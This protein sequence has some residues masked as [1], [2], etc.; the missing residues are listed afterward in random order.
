[1]IHHRSPPRRW[2]RRRRRRRTIT[3]HP[4]PEPLIQTILKLLPPKDAIRA[5]LTSK[6]WRSAWIASPLFE[7]DEQTLPFKQAD[8]YDYVDRT[9]ALW[10]NHCDDHTLKM[11]K[12]SLCSDLGKDGIFFP[13]LIE[14]VSIA[15]NRNVKIIQLQNRSKVYSGMISSNDS[16]WSLFSACKSLDVLSMNCFELSLGNSLPVISSVKKLHLSC[17]GI[18]ESSLKNLLSSLPLL[19]ELEVV[20]CFRFTELLISCP[21]L[22]ILVANMFGNTAKYISIDA[23]NLQSFTYIRSL[24]SR[25][26]VRVLKNCKFLKSMIIENTTFHTADEFEECLSQIPFL[27]YLNLECCHMVEEKEGVQISHSNLKSLVVRRCFSLHKAEFNTPN[28]RFFEYSGAVITLF[29]F[30]YCSGKLNA[31]IELYTGYLDGT[32]WFWFVKLRNFVEILTDCEVLSMALH[33]EGFPEELRNNDMLPDPFFELRH[34]N[35]SSSRYLISQYANFF[36]PLVKIFPCVETLKMKT[37]DCAISIEF[38][39]DRDFTYNWKSLTSASN[40]DDHIKESV[41]AIVNSLSYSEEQN[42]ANEYSEMDVRGRNGVNI[43]NLHFGL[44]FK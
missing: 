25:G 7:F 32:E 6:L 35:I 26:S 34:L 30:G 40:N 18:D 29:K 14:F 39:E 42:S 3:D 11:E 24:N 20:F 23:M 41:E 5:S 2:R 17:V 43:S 38:D 9:L 31:K 4:L 8:F 44:E 19:E 33:I 13:R 12:L 36:D 28:L 16:L 37:R 15:T 21:K 22:K 1:M 27:E 10:L